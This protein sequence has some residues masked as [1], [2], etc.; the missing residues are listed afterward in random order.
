MGKRCLISLSQPSPLPSGEPTFSSSSYL[1][2]S[3][4]V[5]L[6][7]MSLLSKFHMCCFPSFKI[8]SIFFEDPKELLMHLNFYFFLLRSHKLCFR[9]EGPHFSPFLPG[10]T[11]VPEGVVS[12][13]NYARISL[14]RQVLLPQWSS[15]ALGRSKPR[16]A[17]PLNEVIMVQMEWP[18][19]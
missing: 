5:I 13:S 16:V 1:A 19:G 3:P 17:G 6:W 10:N 14:Q 18:S 8:L 12:I 4:C 11:L 9:T 7:F 2:L 15:L